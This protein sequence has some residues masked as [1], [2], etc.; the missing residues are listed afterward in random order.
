MYV[1]RGAL[2]SETSLTMARCAVYILCRSP[3]SRI[4]ATNSGDS[5]SFAVIVGRSWE[6]RQVSTAR[7][8][9][10]RIRGIKV[11]NQQSIQNDG[12][13]YG[14]VTESP[15]DQ[16]VSLRCGDD[17]VEDCADKK[18]HNETTNVRKIV[19]IRDVADSYANYELD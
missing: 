4:Y 9:S 18:P 1:V 8:C 16:P 3:T 14:S 10:I 11:S 13:G 7:A 6:T 17:G 5:S 19:H 15:N 12:D 2:K